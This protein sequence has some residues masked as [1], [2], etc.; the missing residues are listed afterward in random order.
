MGQS[1]PFPATALIVEDDAMQREMLSL[2]LEESGYQVIQCESAEAAER[3]LEK[4]AGALCL[5][6]TDVQL[7]G[8][9]TGVELAH[10][11]KDRNPKLD[12]V[13]TSGR[14]LMQ[15]LPDGA[16]FWAKPWAPLDVLREAE[17]A[18]LS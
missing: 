9:M 14:P 11:A 5:L 12:V 3:V 17:I 4:N 18:Q 1:K 16:K 6:L 15:A 2:L 13:V 7:A 8:R 10:V